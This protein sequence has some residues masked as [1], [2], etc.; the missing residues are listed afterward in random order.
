M[1]KQK[2]KINL[3]I[4][5]IVLLCTLNLNAWE[6]NTHRAIDREAIKQSSNLEIFMDNSQLRRDESFKDAQ[7]GKGVR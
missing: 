2:I 5:W 3:G 7:Y 1:I 6:V 4:I